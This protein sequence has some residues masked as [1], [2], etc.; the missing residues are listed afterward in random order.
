MW[1]STGSQ[2]I[3]VTAK[4]TMFGA[5]ALAVVRL[6]LR[7]LLFRA[8]GAVSLISHMRGSMINGPNLFETAYIPIRLLN[9]VSHT[10][11]PTAGLSAGGYSAM[12][13]HTSLQPRGMS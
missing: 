12:A 10:L 9:A 6:K 11:D 8:G 7:D 4:P 5:Q 3:L 2:R 13:Y 1:R